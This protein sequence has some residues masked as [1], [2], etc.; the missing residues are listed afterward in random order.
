MVCLFLGRLSLWLTLLILIVSQSFHTFMT[1]THISGVKTVILKQQTKICSITY[2]NMSIVKLDQNFSS[3]PSFL[4]HLHP[5]AMRWSR[6]KYAS[7]ASMVGG[8]EYT[9]LGL[10]FG[11]QMRKSLC[12]GYGWGFLVQMS[13]PMGP[14]G[15]VHKYGG[16]VHSV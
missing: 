14:S 3:S 9:G 10:G 4:R 7:M 8:G 1:H 2:N 6:T 13:E 5:E 16:M 12:R 15:G 11:A